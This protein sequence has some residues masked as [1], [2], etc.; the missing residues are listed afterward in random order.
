M[1]KFWT[2]SPC[3]L[4]GWRER[5]AEGSEGQSLP[6]PAKKIHRRENEKDRLANDGHAGAR[7]PRA[8][9][10]PESGDAGRR[11]SDLRFGSRKPAWPA[12]P[13]P[14]ESSDRGKCAAHGIDFGHQSAVGARFARWPGGLL[15]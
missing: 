3:R 10:D 8:V 6:R 2:F 12:G 9:R 14:D 5:D 7:H 15:Y 1:S 11:I 13:V 4:P